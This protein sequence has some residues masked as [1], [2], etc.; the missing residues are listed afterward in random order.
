MSDRPSLIVHAVAP[1]ELSEP[2]REELRRDE[3]PPSAPP[4]FVGTRPAAALVVLRGSEVLWASLVAEAELRAFGRGIARAVLLGPPSVQDTSSIDLCYRAVLDYLFAESAPPHLVVIELH[5]GQT[6]HV[7]HLWRLALALDARLTVREAGS[8]T[9]VELFAPGRRGELAELLNARPHALARAM[10]RDAGAAFADRRGAAAQRPLAV[11]LREVGAPPPTVVPR[12]AVRFA[13]AAPDDVRRRP[14][15]FGLG[16]VAALGDLEGRHQ[17]IGR[18]GD[19]IIFQMVVNRSAPV[20]QLLQRDI[21]EQLTAPVALI[22]DARTDP[23]F[24]NR[25]IFTAGLQW[26]AEWARENGVRTIVALIRTDNAPSLRAAAKAG[27]RHV[28]ELS[29]SPT[30]A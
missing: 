1:A 22:T 18:V 23:E 20:L 26:V 25:S 9:R 6:D 30:E 19:R 12:V 24:R 7:D 27:F 16:L 5:D 11:F 14:R 3:H 21:Q 2:I 17:F 29:L 15:R 10:L 28:G 13:E 8:R 4:G